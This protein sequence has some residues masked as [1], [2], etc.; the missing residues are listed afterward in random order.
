MLALCC[1][2]A[3]GL[4]AG[5]RGPLGGAGRAGL[6]LAE[7]EGGAGTSRGRCRASPP[8]QPGLDLLRPLPADQAQGSL[9]L[10]VA[11]PSA[12]P[13]ACPLGGGAPRLR[14]L[15]EAIGGCVRLASELQ[16]HLARL[17]AEVK[18][19]LG[20]PE[21]EERPPRAEAASTNRTAQP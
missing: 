18:R 1:T 13:E 5:V 7:D 2:A 4:A 10:R 17:A 14:Q 15:E 12:P 6:S 16:G 8:R 9:T 20:S 3:G 19:C 11:D 21:A